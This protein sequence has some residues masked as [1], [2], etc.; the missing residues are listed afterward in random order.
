MRLYEQIARDFACTKW[1]NIG[2]NPNYAQASALLL[3][4]HHQH[5]GEKVSVSQPFFLVMHR[6][7]NPNYAQALALLLNFWR[8]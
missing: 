3:Q 2:F 7:V 1:E 6:R 4:R 5:A 8:Q